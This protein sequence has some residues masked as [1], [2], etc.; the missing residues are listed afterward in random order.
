MAR[1]SISHRQVMKM[2]IERSKIMRVIFNQGEDDCH[3]KR[4]L[5]ADKSGVQGQKWMRISQRRV[6]TTF[7]DKLT[8]FVLSGRKETSRALRSLDNKKKTK[9]CGWLAHMGLSCQRRRT[10]GGRE[11]RDHRGCPV[12]PGAIDTGLRDTPSYCDT[13][14]YYRDVTLLLRDTSVA[15]YS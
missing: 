14:G 5:P 7:G 6:Q 12:S 2:Q 10:A 3:V 8:Y 11:Q 1:P 9:F 4:A 13:L 15:L